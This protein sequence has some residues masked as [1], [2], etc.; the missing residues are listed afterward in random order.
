MATGYVGAACSACDVD[1]FLYNGNCIRAFTGSL[2]LGGGLG[3]ASLS[4]WL[5]AGMATITLLSVVVVVT[6]M[7]K[8]SNINA[9]LKRLQ[10]AVQCK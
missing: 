5:L 10:Q 1:Y 3:A 4:A 8:N 9:Q 7:A 6:M 2:L